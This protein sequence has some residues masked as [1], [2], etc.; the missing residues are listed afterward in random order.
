MTRVWQLLRD[1]FIAVGSGR[2]R[3][4]IV[5]GLLTLVMGGAV[6]VNFAL[7]GLLESHLSKPPQAPI[8]APPS[9]AA[10]GTG[11]SGSSQ[12]QTG[13]SEG[14][15]GGAARSTPSRS[16]ALGGGSGPTNGPA[17]GTGPVTGNEPVLGGP[18]PGN[19][20]PPGSGS[21]PNYGPPTPGLAEF[22][23]PVL[24]VV[25]LLAVLALAMTWHRKR[26][27][28]RGGR[29]GDGQGVPLRLLAPMPAAPLGRRAR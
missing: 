15:S 22:P 2:S 12:G 19:G 14:A 1:R 21:P 5:T 7:F 27:R 18:S 4:V 29:P 20:P 13:G 6:V 25:P 24:A 9:H 10:V 23:L 8:A 26:P 17:I 3:R 16:F 11:T 28:G